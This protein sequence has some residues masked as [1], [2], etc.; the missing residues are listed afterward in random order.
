MFFVKDGQFR[1]SCSS[2][3]VTGDEECS[4]CGRK[5]DEGC[6]EEDKLMQAAIE[7]EKDNLK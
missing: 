5:E 3:N 1:G 6:G 7:A 2:Q 4:I